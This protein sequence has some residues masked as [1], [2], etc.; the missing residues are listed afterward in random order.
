MYVQLSCPSVRPSTNNGAQSTEETSMKLAAV[1][2][3]KILTDH[4][5]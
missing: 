2:L 5:N 4:F 1:D 3:H